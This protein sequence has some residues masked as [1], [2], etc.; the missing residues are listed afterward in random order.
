MRFIKYRY[1]KRN[2]FFRSVCVLLMITISALIIDAKLRPAIIDFAFLEA[3][4]AAET[5]VAEAVEKILSDDETDYSRIVTVNYSDENRI[6]G[7]TTDI[8]KMNLFKSEIAE[9]VDK[10]LK[11]MTQ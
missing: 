9:A 1:V 11:R 6:T 8:V 2:V 4:S 10:A 3:K 5:T 7:I